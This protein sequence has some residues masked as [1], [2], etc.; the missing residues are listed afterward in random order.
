MI[1]SE[2]NMGG[3]V[4][5]PLAADLWSGIQAGLSGT[6][7]VELKVLKS[8]KVD[9]DFIAKNNDVYGTEHQMILDYMAA[10]AKQ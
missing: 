2:M 4:D 3:A 1:P 9:I 7:V 10:M 8:G 5:R 6:D